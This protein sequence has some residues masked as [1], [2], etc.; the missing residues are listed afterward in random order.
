MDLLDAAPQL[1][2]ET[3]ITAHTIQLRTGGEIAGDPETVIVGV[4]SLEAAQPGELAFA[5]SG[6]ERYIRRSCASA[7]IVSPQ[8]PILEGRTFIR[9]KDPRLAFAK[10]RYLFQPERTPRAGI[11]RHALVAPDVYLGEAVTVRE[12]AVIRSR[13][14]I[15]RETII[16]SGVHVGE[17][18]T[19]GEQCFIGP[20]V[21]IMHGTRIGNRVIIH[22]GSVIGVDGFG[23]VWTEGRYLKIPQL[24]RVII[25]D[26]VELG[27]NV[28]VDRAMLGATIVKRGTKVDNLVQIAYNDVIGE[29]VI[30]SGQVGLAGSVHVGNRAILAGQVGV[31]DHLTI[32]DDARVGGA[33]GVTRDVRNRE[34]VWGF[35]ARDIRKV[36]RE[37]AALALLPRIIKR[38]TGSSPAS[39]KQRSRS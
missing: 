28:C 17:D 22:G 12:C 10:A 30:I 13:A 39:N 37:L 31:A 34:T 29:D 6:Y 15:G 33:S 23:Y 25:E 38:L 20:N 16:E 24:G 4:N 32:G 35:P 1:G 21:V 11:D 18:V 2:Q 8:F 26:D 7:I 3:R 14:R 27:A 36:K 5:E 19:I 9:V